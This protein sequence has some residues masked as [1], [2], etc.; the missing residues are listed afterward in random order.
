MLGKR[1]LWLGVDIGSVRLR[2]AQGVLDGGQARV[3]KIA[4]R[5]L[6]EG[7]ASSGVIEDTEFVAALIDEAVREIGGRQRV[8]VCSIAE[9]DALLRAVSFPRMTP[10]ERARAAVFEAARHIRYDVREA[11][12]RTHPAKGCAHTWLLGIARAAAARS[13]VKACTRGGLRVR[14]MDYDGCALLRALPDYDAVVDI[15]LR[16]SAVHVR[17]PHGPVTSQIYTGGRDVTVQVE[18]ELHLDHRSAETRKRILGTAGAGNDAR[19]SLVKEIAGAIKASAAVATIT[20]V[21]LVGNGS[22]LPGIAQAVGVASGT[23]CELGVGELLRGGGYPDDVI[24]SG[25]ADWTL[26]AALAAWR[27]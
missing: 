13:R 12:V 17:M 22:R 4:V 15:G 16:R 27:P 24:R 5:D 25:A 8:C 26:A 3:A 11:I 20:S 6:P 1:T 7:A 14:A 2:V 19:L 18:R 10:P 21:A 9:P 23:R